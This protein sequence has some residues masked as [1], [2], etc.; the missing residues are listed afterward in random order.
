MRFIVWI[1]ELSTHLSLQREES[2]L[3][4]LSASHNSRQDAQ[5]QF[6]RRSVYSW[7][8]VRMITVISLVAISAATLV[9]GYIMSKLID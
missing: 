5:E 2:N 4:G 3:M 7:L 1:L 8:G 9:A 6:V